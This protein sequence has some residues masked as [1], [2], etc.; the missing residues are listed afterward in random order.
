MTGLLTH[1]SLGRLDLERARLLDEQGYLL[2]R[3]AIPEGW[4]GPLRDAFEGGA[5]PSVR[6]PVPRG[7]DWRH[8]L[9]DLDSTVQ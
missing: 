3:G 5:S 8:S 1:T 4:I 6:W 7:V 9:L 2:L